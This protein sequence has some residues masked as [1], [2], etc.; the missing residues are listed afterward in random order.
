MLNIQESIKIIRIIPIAN[1]EIPP[2]ATKSRAH[3]AAPSVFNF[4]PTNLR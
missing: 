1:T 2:Q 4:N 3:L